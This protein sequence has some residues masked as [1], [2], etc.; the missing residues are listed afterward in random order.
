M[1]IKINTAPG[2]RAE[3]KFFCLELDFGIK[4]EKVVQYENMHQRMW[5]GK[6]RV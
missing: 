4:R 6:S 3:I 2:G 1:K 5:C